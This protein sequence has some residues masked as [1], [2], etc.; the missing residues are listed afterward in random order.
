MR[1]DPEVSWIL[2]GRSPDQ[3]PMARLAEY[4]SQ[5]A[6]ILGDV[7]HVHFARLEKACTKLVA[8]MRPGKT[9]QKAQSRVYAVRDRR[10]PL[11]AMRAYTRINE[12]VGEDKGSARVMFGAAA[13][14]RFP[15]STSAPVGQFRIIQDTT[16]TGRL[17]ALLEDEN[18][19]LKARI[20][21]RTGNRY[22][23]CTVDRD[24]S[25]QLRNFF[26]DAVK[27][28]GRG[29]WTRPASGNW[30]CENLH[31]VKVD[32][33]KD[34]SLRDAINALR[35]IEADWQDDPLG[36]WDSLEERGTVA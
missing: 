8:K 4:M 22:I 13:V 16:I 26:L 24:V 19:K 20:R 25:R 23:N 9:A 17:Y 2:E 12:M 14:L 35:A 1:S 3:I 29:V 30:T 34:V 11:D 27:V 15:G 6:V 33:V 36:D 7:E 18:G 31:I 10:A 21:P 5:L 28:Y 32:P